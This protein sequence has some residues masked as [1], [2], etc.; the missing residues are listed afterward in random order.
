MDTREDLPR[1][2]VDTIHDWQRVKTTVTDA[3]LVKLDTQM[4]AR[5]STA[6][7]S[8]LLQHMN[9]VLLLTI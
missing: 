6:N 3:A 8:A 2:A 5:R 9:Q 7:R 4:A 1:I